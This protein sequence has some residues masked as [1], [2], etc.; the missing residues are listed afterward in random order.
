MAAYF[1]GGW[2]LQD[3]RKRGAAIMKKSGV[4]DDLEIVSVDEL[5]KSAYY[6]DFLAPEGLQRFA[7]VKF[8]C[9]DDLWC[10]SIQRSLGETPFSP[11]EK[12][13]LA[14]LSRSLSSAAAIARALGYATTNTALE[15]FEVSD[16]AVLLIDRVGKVI[17]ANRSAEPLLRGDVTISR[18]KLLAKDQ[19]ASRAVEAALHKLLWAS[20]STLSAPIPL[21]REG[22]R[23]LLVYLLKLASQSANALAECQAIAVLID[24]DRRGVFKET[25]LR[26]S[27]GFTAA[28]A[29]LAARVSSGA[30][31]D[32][33]TESLGISKETGRNQLK[34]VF[35]KTGVHRQAEL[36]AVMGSTLNAANGTTQPPTI[37]LKVRS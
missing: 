16:T 24:P 1:R 30:S 22:Q 23:P 28:E 12:Q 34:S 9:G 21:P 36:V 2:H 5:K 33:V 35:A 18:G 31:L 4:V 15:A 3:E 25:T 10:L 13:K 32:S 26:A 11:E 7:G 14:K 19:N 8:A 17:R 20:G 29:K 27:F 37:E 6:Q